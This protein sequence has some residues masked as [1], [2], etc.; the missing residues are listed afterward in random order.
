[1]IQDPAGQEEMVKV[2]MGKKQ[3]IQLGHVPF[4]QVK[5][6]EQFFKGMVRGEFFYFG[7]NSLIS[8]VIEKS[9]C[10]IRGNSRINE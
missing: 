4:Y 10:H 7:W 3:N 5:A 1:M 6:P 9:L 8:P 2:A